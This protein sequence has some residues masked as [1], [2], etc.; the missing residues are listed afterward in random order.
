M[1]CVSAAVLSD[2]SYAWQHIATAWCTKQG[3]QAARWYELEVQVVCNTCRYWCDVP[4]GCPTGCETT[5]PIYRGV[6][7]WRDCKSKRAKV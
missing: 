1:L 5:C 3:V 2:V 7:Y 6:L 4:R